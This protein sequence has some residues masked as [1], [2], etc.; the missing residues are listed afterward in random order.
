MFGD[1]FKRAP[2]MRPFLNVGFPFDIATGTFYKGLHNEYVLNGGLSHFTGVAGV[3]NLYK[4]TLTH[5]FHLTVLDRYPV[6]YGMVYDTEPP[7]VTYD[8]FRQLAKTMGNLAG[9]DLEKRLLLTDTTVV[10]GNEW[11]AKIKKAM[12]A[13][14]D[15]KKDKYV[16]VPFADRAGNLISMLEPNSIEVD[17]LSMMTLDVVDKILDENDIGESGANIEAMKGQAA[18]SQMIMQLPYLT[19]SSNTY[20]MATAHVGKTY[21]LDPRQPVQKQLSFLKQDLKLKNVPEKFTFLTNNLYFAATGSPLMNRATKTPEFPRNSEDATTGDTDL[22]L[23]TFVVLRA[24][25]GPSGLPIELVFSQSE[26]YNPDLTAL[27]FL[28]NNDK[29]GIGGNDRNYYLELYPDCSLS[30]TTVRGKLAKDARLRRAMKFTAEIAFM[31]AY[32]HRWRE[33]LAD[34]KDIYESLVA[35]G[36]D[37]DKILDTQGYYNFLSSPKDRCWDI[38][39]LDLLRIHAGEFEAEWCK[40]DANAKPVKP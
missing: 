37:W 4:S 6:I 22:M 27:N 31:R 11:F 24:K 14:M 1:D 12:K 39:T 16:L 15:W 34:P 13:K 20:F 9:D 19:T 36:Y 33:L 32:W 18:K 40:K 30:R 8:R 21:Q 10:V 25:N 23:I 35:K 7:S 28:R 5:F 26:G 38:S 17:S 3:P 29:F 2:Q